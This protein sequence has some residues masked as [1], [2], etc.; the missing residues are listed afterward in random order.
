MPLSP[1][2]AAGLDRPLRDLTQSSAAVAS[3]GTYLGLEPTHLRDYLNI[4]WKRKWLILSLL[5][6]VTTLVAIQ[7]YR[8]PSIYEAATMI[9]IEPKTRIGIKTKDIVI[10]QGTDPGYWNT[11]LQLLSLIHI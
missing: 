4:V 10:N 3:G 2:T 7:M 5:V 11:Q 8:L 1:T 6:V 9:Q